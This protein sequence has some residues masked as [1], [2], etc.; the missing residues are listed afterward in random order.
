M[1][2]TASTFLTEMSQKERLSGLLGLLGTMVGFVYCARGIW[3]AHGL[4]LRA[5]MLS[6]PSLQRS[7]PSNQLRIAEFL[8]YQRFKQIQLYKLLA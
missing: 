6:G 3:P 4:R 2:C 5:G 8:C 1:T 7:R